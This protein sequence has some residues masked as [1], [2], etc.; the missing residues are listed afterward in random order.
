[1]WQVILD[2]FRDIIVKKFLMCKP[3]ILQK[4]SFFP[5]TSGKNYVG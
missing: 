4:E 2:Y 5:S 3:V 1:M